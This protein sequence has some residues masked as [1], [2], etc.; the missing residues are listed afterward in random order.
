[1]KHQTHDK[2]TKKEW[3]VDPQTAIEEKKEWG[4]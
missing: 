2:K 4:K 1:M 3:I